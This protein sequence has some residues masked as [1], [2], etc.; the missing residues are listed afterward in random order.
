MILPWALSHLSHSFSGDLTLS[1]GS[2]Y[3]LSGHGPGLVLPGKFLPEPQIPDSSVYWAPSGCDPD[4]SAASESTVLLLTLAPQ[5]VFPIPGAFLPPTPPSIQ[6]KWESPCHYSLSLTLMADHSPI[7][8]GLYLLHVSDLFL[9]ISTRL[10]QA[11]PSL[12]WTWLPP[13]LWAGYFL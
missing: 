7:I 1:R 13:C 8:P 4:P 12:I 10:V 9:S 2:H 5:A 11:S 3:S 6:E